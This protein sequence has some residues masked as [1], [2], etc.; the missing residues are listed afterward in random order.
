MDGIDGELSPRDAEVVRTIEEEGLSLFTFDGLRR[1]TGSHPE[2]LS[3]TLERLEDSGVVVRSP[4][5]YSLTDRSRSGSGLRP[6]NGGTKSVPILHTFLPYAGSAAKV[7]GALKGR[8]F[9]NIRWVG[10]ADGDDGIVMKWV[11]DDG[12]AIIDARIAG[13]QLDVEARVA[14]DSDLPKAVRAA[15]QLVG[16]ISRLYSSPRPGGRVALMQIGHFSP[17]AM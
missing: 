8:W 11:T 9:D 12:T 10:M 16:R 1:I 14:S 13:G 3:R 6:A 5:G 4:E 2:T 17:H 7:V 15:H